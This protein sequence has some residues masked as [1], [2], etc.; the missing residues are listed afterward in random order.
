MGA[1][2]TTLAKDTVTDDERAAFARKSVLVTGA[3]SGLGFDCCK[4]LAESGWGRIILACRNKQRGEDAVKDL[5]KQTGKQVFE[6]V[7]LDTENKAACRD[8]ASNFDGKLDCL[9]LNAGKMLPK[10]EALKPSPDGYCTNAAMHVLG[11]ITFT[12]AL[13]SQGKFSA[14]AT[15]IYVSSEVARGMST[16]SVAPPVVPDNKE[17]LQQLMKGEVC[18]L[19]SGK[20]DDLSEYGR[21]KLL[22][23]MHFSA[24]ARKHSQFHIFSVSPGSTRG[25]QAASEH[26][27]VAALVPVL[28]YFASAFGMSHPLEFGTDRYVQLANRPSDFTS[29]TFYASKSNNPVGDMGPQA[30][31]HPVLEDTARQDLVM[32]TLMELALQPSTS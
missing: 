14:D 30:A 19:P 27:T 17:Q 20:W 11:P 8:V 21:M 3:N 23:T 13:I 1:G 22:A 28:M 25:T 4:Q 31:F 12:D 7:I 2:N 6:L 24:L 29:G 9:V 26:G 10:T 5:E 18:A 32:Q 16:M 15:I